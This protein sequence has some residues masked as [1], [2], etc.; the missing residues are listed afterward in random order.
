MKFFWERI[1][2]YVNNGQKFIVLPLKTYGMRKYFS[3]QTYLVHMYFGF[4]II[5]NW[6]K[7][8]SEL[9]SLKVLKL[10]GMYFKR[11]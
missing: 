6:N 1:K 2:D 4:K 9:I 8:H 7:L 11:T 3:F 10:C 5:R